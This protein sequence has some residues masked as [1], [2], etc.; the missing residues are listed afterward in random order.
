M[1]FCWRFQLTQP[2]DYRKGFIEPA[3]LF[4]DPLE[5]ALGQPTNV[6]PSRCN[7]KISLL[8]CP[9]LGY[10][11]SWTQTRKVPKSNDGASGATKDTDI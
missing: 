1:S 2:V 6:A 11:L 7:W 9:T 5:A 8:H 3:A 10:F 4:V